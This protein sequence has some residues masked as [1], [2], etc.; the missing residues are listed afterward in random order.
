MSIFA[1]KRIF[2]GL[3][4]DNRVSGV[5]TGDMEAIAPPPTTLTR[6]CSRFP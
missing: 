2:R 4:V 6:W 1:E 3:L 5:A